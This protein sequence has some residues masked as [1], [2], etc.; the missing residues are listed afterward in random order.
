MKY[1]LETTCVDSD[2]DSIIDM[3]ESSHEVTRATFQRRCDWRS[4]AE[5]LGYASHHRHGLTLAR[6][7]HVRYHR[8]TYQGRPCYFATWS[9]IE[10]VFTQSDAFNG[11]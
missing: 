1:V 6:D 5:S 10:H 8:S 2:G 11:R 3:V 9:V 4:W 7:R